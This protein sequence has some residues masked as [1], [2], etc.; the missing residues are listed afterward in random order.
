[1]RYME[2]QGDLPKKAGAATLDFY[3]PESG[4]VR[5]VYRKDDVIHLPAFSDLEMFP[6]VPDWTTFLAIQG[7][8]AAGGDKQQ[9][10]FGGTDENPF[11]VRMDSTVLSGFYEGGPGRF[12]EA[13]RPR[14]ITELETKLK[15]KARRQGD[16]FALDVGYSWDELTHA[17]DVLGGVQLQVKELPAMELLQTRHV[18]HGQYARMHTR[19]HDME[20]ISG[21]VVAPDH[22]DLELTVPYVVG[23][24]AFLY[25]PPHAD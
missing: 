17:A 9:V 13:I 22:A 14:E 18:L 16:I 24:T 3:E 15:R 12:F 19:N 20:F 1:M 10:F 11:L 5:N 21:T 7:G 2:M 6:L 4:G 8:W 25:D 23:Q